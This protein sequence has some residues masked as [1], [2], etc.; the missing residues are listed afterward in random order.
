[1]KFMTDTNKVETQI[2]GQNKPKLGIIGLG[3]GSRIKKELSQNYELVWHIGSKTKFENLLSVDYVYIA[4]PLEF[5]FEHAVHFLALGVFVFVEKPASFTV[6]A[7]RYLIEFAARNNTCIYFSDVYRFRADLTI[8]NVNDVKWSKTSSST[9]FV[10][11]RL[12]Y[13]YL[14]LIVLKYGVDVKIRDVLCTYDCVS[15]CIENDVTRVEFYFEQAALSSA[16]EHDGKKIPSGVNGPIARMTHCARLTPDEIMKNNEVTIAAMKLY[17]SIRANMP[18]VT[19]V[20]AGIFGCQTAITLAKQGYKV[21]IIERNEDILSC[22]SDINQYRV[23]RGY[24]YPRSDDTVKQC[25]DSLQSFYKNFWPAIITNHTSYYSISKHD[26]K[27]TASEYLNFL[28]RNKLPYKVVKP[29]KNCALTVEVEEYLYNPSVIRDLLLKRI[30][31]LGVEVSFGVQF[32]SDMNIE[33]DMIVIAVYSASG[34]FNNQIYQHELCEK[35]IVKLPTKYRDVSH[36]IMDGPFTC[37]DPYGNEGYHV[38]GNVVHAI[39]QTQFEKFPIIPEQFS[40]LLNMGPI[41]APKI[42]KFDQFKETYSEYFDDVEDIIHVSSMFTFRTVLPKKEA[43]DARPT[44]ITTL[45]DGSIQVFSG[46]IVTC[47]TAATQVL[48]LCNSKLNAPK[49]T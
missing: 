36:V 4:S 30:Q 43:D 15:F 12:G 9:D 41:E 46:K 11:A 5:H 37:I 49:L 3:Y 8:N 10:L 23:H 35:P 13:H 26:S 17:E 16:H 24:H 6:E 34:A 33:S 48:E 31:T 25:T 1:M 7:T 21:K 40:S 47:C 32:E 39:H 42:S 28:E 20:G 19:V 18:T 22:A 29:H 2:I 14:Y 38:I 44:N 45:R 27:V